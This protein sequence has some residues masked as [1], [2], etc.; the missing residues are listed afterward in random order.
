MHGTQSPSDWVCRWTHLIAPGGQVLDLACGGGR[1]MQ[2]LAAQGHR[3]LGLDRDPQALALAGAFGPTLLADLENDTWP[4]T[5]RTFDA[6]V[7]TN[8]LWRP[9]WPQ[10]LESL[11][12]DGV[13][14]YETF[15]QGHETVGRPSRA[16]FLLAPGELL[17]VARQGQLRVLAYEDGFLK[18]PE[19]F[20]QR[21]TAVR[22]SAASSPR[23]WPLAPAATAP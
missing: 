2:W 6:V 20:V 12:P 16:D 5:G 11:G 17:E 23:R 21:I 19:R 15:A 7:V 13:L 9:L 22:Q 18:T 8:Y 1:H 10:I 4:L 14:I 3:V